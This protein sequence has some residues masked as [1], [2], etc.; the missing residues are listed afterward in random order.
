WL[1]FKQDDAWAGDAEADDLLEGVTP[2]PASK[3]GARTVNKAAKTPARSATARTP[4]RRATKKTASRAKVTRTS[5]GSR[6]RTD[7]AA[8]AAKLPGAR[9]RA[10]ATDAPRPQLARLVAKPPD[11]ERWLH[12]LKWDGYRLLAALRDREPRLWSRNGLD[13]TA[14]VPEVDDA[15]AAL[16]VRDLLVDGELI[17]GQGRREDFNLLQ[18][19]LSGERQGRLRLV[20]FDLLHVGGV[21]LSAAPL[22]E[23]KQLLERLLRGAPDALAYSSHG[24]GDGAAALQAAL[25]AGFEGLVSKRGDAAYHPGRGDDWRKTKA[26]ASAEYAV[27]GYTPPKG[28]RRGIG[29]L[30]LATPDPEH[31][32]R[33]VG[34][35]GSGLDDAQLRALGERLAGKG[36]DAPTVHVPA[37]DTDLRQARWLPRPA[38]VVE[39]FTRGTGGSGLLRQASFKALRPDKSVAAL[40]DAGGDRI[41]A[42]ERPMAKQAGTGK[43]AAKRGASSA[44]TKGKS[45]STASRA[46]SRAPPELS[47]P[48]KVL[49][50]DDGITKQQLA[51]YYAAAM[52]WLL[53]EIAGRPLSL[54]RCPSGLRAQ[55]FFQKHATPGMDLVSRV[56]IEESGG[57]R[58]DYLYVTDAASVLELV[59]FNTIEFHPWGARVEDVEHCDR[60]VFDLDPD[61]SV[62]WPEVV[63]AARQLRG[64]LGQAGLGSFVRTSGR[65]GLHL[66]VPPAPP[67]TR[68][69]TSPPPAS[70]GARAGSSSTGCATA[71][72]PPAWPASRCAR[73]P[74]PRSRCRC[75][76]RNWAGSR[77][78]TPGTS[79]TP[80]R[81]CRACAATP[82]TD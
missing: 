22:H 79:A 44:T 71:A 70:A 43:A 50:P 36:R 27:V 68:C 81:G 74:A 66:G 31:G 15:L 4:A 75:A 61:P 56:P 3:R 67:P 9:R 33:Y 32:W 28:S 53:P 57:G 58:E 63:A 7:W 2:P 42:E 11:G 35:V 80:W 51:D 78:A 41:E 23:R 20:L 30:L 40:A 19:V 48:E 21:D 46:G 17:A 13:W 60:L 55:C 14:R 45:R 52:D 64:F 73:V 34:R 6:R 62:G 5:A 37:N 47:S 24:M 39:V 25:E 29:S 72:A 1:L 59:Q 38:F 77:R 18:Q 26:L 12:E 54:V 69:A 82:G 76:G 65:T 10:L 16:G 49:F 8:L